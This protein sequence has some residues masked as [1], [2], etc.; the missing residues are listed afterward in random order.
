[1][2]DT[3]KTIENRIQ[4]ALSALRS[5]ENPKIASTAREFD[6]PY[7]RLRARWN[8][9]LSRSARAPANRVLDEA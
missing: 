7:H 1:M 6:V 4:D 5:Q 9:R 2:P 3:Y 8:G